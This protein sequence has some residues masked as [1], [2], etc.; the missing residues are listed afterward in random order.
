MSGILIIKHCK[1]KTKKELHVW[2]VPT[3]TFSGISSF[4]DNFGAT[5]FTVATSSFLLF[6]LF[7]SFTKLSDKAI[8]GFSSIVFSTITVSVTIFIFLDFF[9]SFFGISLSVVSFLIFF[10]FFNFLSFF[11]PSPSPSISGTHSSTFSILA[12]TTSF[13]STATSSLGREESSLAARA[14]LPL[15]FFTADSNFSFLPFRSWP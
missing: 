5:T 15:A 12:A 3:S 11:S 1:M 9:S 13:S 4:F 10:S 14:F 6:L 8:S 2:N 7:V